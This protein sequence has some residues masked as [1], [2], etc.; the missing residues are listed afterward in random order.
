MLNER[1]LFLAM[2]GHTRQVWSEHFLGFPCPASEGRE[3]EAYQWLHDQAN[4]HFS[5]A[6]PG[7]WDATPKN[8]EAQSSAEYRRSIVRTLAA[9]KNVIGARIP[10]G[11]GEVCLPLLRPRDDLLDVFY[12]R[13]APRTSKRTDDDLAQFGSVKA[14]AI[15]DFLKPWAFVINRILLLTPSCCP[16][17]QPSQVLFDTDDQEIQYERGWFDLGRQSL[18]RAVSATGT[19]E[20]HV[21]KVAGFKNWLRLETERLDLHRF[22]EKSGR[23]E[24]EAQTKAQVALTL[25]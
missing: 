25:F 13:C 17:N 24:S 5:D 23:P 19:L 22:G 3:W 18:E 2:T 6:F 4:L 21:K 10:V 11:P 8:L 7:S 15:E 12:L 16:G 1:D 20:R 9:G 14:G